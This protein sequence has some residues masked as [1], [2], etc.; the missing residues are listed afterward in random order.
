MT[1]KPK[2]ISENVTLFSIDPLVYVV[3][4]FLSSDECAAFIE[5]GVGV[6]WK[7]LQS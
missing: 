4:G 2:Q 5:V 6:R 3:S 7:E 1:I